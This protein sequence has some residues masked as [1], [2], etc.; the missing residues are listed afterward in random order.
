MKKLLPILF[1]CSV[2]A[3]DSP[4]QEI[5][6]RNAFTLVGEPKP[7]PPVANLVRPKVNLYLTGIVN[8]KGSTNVYLYSKDIGKKFLTLNYKKRTDEGITLISINKNL[9]KVSNNGRIELLSF[10]SHRNPSIITA[11][12]SK[13]PTIIKK[14]S[15]GKS[16]KT[17]PTP[18]KASVVKVPSRLPKIDPKMLQ[19][20]L[21]YLDKVE[22]K[23]KREYI[24]QRLEKLQSGQQNIDQKI[25]TN[26]RRR[27]YDERRRRY[28]GSQK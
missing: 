22:D 13:K 4:Y 15:K 11:G 17:L 9:V 16:S 3:Q 14:D 10:D 7:L 25:E 28:D 26:E 19:R 18:P 24:L 1:A 23:E 6:K 20:G 5:A 21:E 8:F 2:V 12:P 27:Q